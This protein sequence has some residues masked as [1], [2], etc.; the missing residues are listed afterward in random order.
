MR[1][2]EEIKA[3]YP[4]SNISQVHKQW[5]SS[6]DSDADFVARSQTDF[7]ADMLQYSDWSPF[8]TEKKNGK[9]WVLIFTRYARKVSSKD[10]V[11]KWQENIYVHF[12]P[13]PNGL[14]V[15]ASYQKKTFWGLKAVGSLLYRK[16]IDEWMTFILNNFSDEDFIPQAKYLSGDDQVYAVMQMSP[17]YVDLIARHPG[18]KGVMN[19]LFKDTKNGV[20]KDLFN[21]RLQGEV[22]FFSLMICVYLAKAFS[23]YGESAFSYL[24]RLELNL[25]STEFHLYEIFTLSKSVKYYADFFRYSQHSFNKLVKFLETKSVY[26]ASTFNHEHITYMR[27][28]SNMLNQLD[29]ASRRVARDWYRGSRTI[30]ELHDYLSLMIQQMEVKDLPI[31]V[32]ALSHFKGVV[33]DG[34]TCVIPE[35][36]HDLLRWGNSA[37][38][39]IGS[40][41]DRV[42][43]GK[44]YC[45][46]F[47]RD[48][49]NIGFAEVSIR[50]ELQQL[51][52]NYNKPL[53]TD[54]GKPI[55][56]YLK[57]K[58][59]DTSNYWGMD[60]PQL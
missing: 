59:V 46:A 21:G 58:G 26:E 1:N 17:Y 31:E 39:C 49:V 29:R 43:Q 14:R 32:K 27:D 16:G 23:G 15:M 9:G 13:T 51:L 42:R 25:T 10:N 35:T 50:M 38:I 28:I 54:I 4:A 44:T 3:R 48:G 60:N 52:G 47:A 53:D 8:F 11:Q 55:V 22:D 20:P 18:I 30:K 45:F 5:L 57:K 12:T 33:G 37:N 24:R 41:A 40:Y 36:T 56:A 19:E 34:I 7:C 2:P 6:I